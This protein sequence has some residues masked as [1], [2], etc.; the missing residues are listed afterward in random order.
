M[1][2]LYSVL[3]NTDRS[4]KALE[5]NAEASA[6]PDTVQPTP[7]TQLT[8]GQDSLLLSLLQLM[9]S[10]LLVLQQHPSVFQVPGEVV[11]LPLQLLSRLLG[12]FIHAL[13]LPKLG[14]GE[15]ER[16]V[17]VPHFQGQHHVRKGMLGERTSEEFLSASEAAS[18]SPALL[19]GIVW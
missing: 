8:V 9:V 16:F 13:Q 7:V 12:L 6:Y 19:G 3:K 2:G 11:A 15:R 4:W 17:G 14:K 10:A 1:K 5:D 18:L